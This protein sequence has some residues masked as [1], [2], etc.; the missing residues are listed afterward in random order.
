M[1]R[2]SLMGGIA[3]TLVTVLLATFT[4]SSRDLVSTEDIDA[5]YDQDN[6]T[7]DAASFVP[8]AS[9]EV[10]IAKSIQDAGKAL[11]GKDASKLKTRATVG[12][13]TGPDNRGNPVEGRRVRLVVVDNLPLTFPSGPYK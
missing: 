12:L 13:Y 10:V 9:K 3:A 5:I 8:D 2:W 1:K 7:L 4:F 11:I 6:Q